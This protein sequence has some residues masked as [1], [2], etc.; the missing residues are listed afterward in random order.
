MFTVLPE[1]AN[2]CAW[3]RRSVLQEKKVLIKALSIVNFYCRP[4]G[5]T[6]ITSAQLYIWD[7]WNLETSQ[8]P[9]KQTDRHTDRH[10][11]LDVVLQTQAGAE[12]LVLELGWAVAIYSFPPK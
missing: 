2:P 1:M 8:D 3:G 9:G 7:Q 4:A 12:P 11:G 5:E 10:T 6:P